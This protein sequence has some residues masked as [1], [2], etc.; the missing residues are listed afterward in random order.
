MDVVSFFEMDNRFQVPA[1]F[2]LWRWLQKLLGVPIARHKGK[3]EVF[4][5]DDLILHLANRTSSRP[6]D[7]ILAIAALFGLDVGQY[8]DLDP[9]E[10]MIKFLIEHNE[11][12]VRYD[13]LFVQGE[14]LL[15]QGFSWA[16]KS[17][18]HRPLDVI[19]RGKWQGGWAI[20]TDQGLVGADYYCL[21]LESR[22]AEEAAPLNYY[23]SGHNGEMLTVRFSYSIN[24]EEV[25]L[26][27]YDALLMKR[28]LR[29]GEDG[30]AATLKVELKEKMP[31]GTVCLHLDLVGFADVAGADPVVRTDERVN[32]QVEEYTG[33]VIIS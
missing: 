6:E 24:P 23:A 15:I 19:V 27:T 3:E 32:I 9:E 13:I 29:V 1:F 21:L 20:V 10:R 12:K 26:E 18:L 11:S 22:W 16:P 7:E 28:R 4:L 8:V 5:L 30:I 14:K 2:E 25:E 33:I 17:F 31:D